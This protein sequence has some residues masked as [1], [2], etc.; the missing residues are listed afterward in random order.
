MY[1]KRIKG[2]NQRWGCVFRTDKYLFRLNCSDHSC[3]RSSSLRNHS[4]LHDCSIRRYFSYSFAS[5]GGVV[6]PGC[7]CSYTASQV[8]SSSC[9][10]SIQLRAYSSEGDGRNASE[11]SHKALNDGPNIDKGD[12]GKIRCEKVREDVRHCNT[13][14]QL[15]EQEQKEWLHN[16]KLSIESKRRESPFLTRREKFKSEFLRRVV[17]WEKINISWETFPYYIQ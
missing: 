17:P 9:L 6:A 2:G 11:N 12:K 1:A 10:N 5:R 16:E 7:S 4:S 15:G 8:R 13:H 3:S 14:A